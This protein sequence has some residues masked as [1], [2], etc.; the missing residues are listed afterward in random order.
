MRQDLTAAHKFSSYCRAQIFLIRPD[1]Q[2]RPIVPHASSSTPGRSGN[3]PPG[4]AGPAPPVRC[5]QVINSC[6]QT[7]A[8]RP[9]PSGV[10][11]MTHCLRIQGLRHLGRAVLAA[12]LLALGALAPSSGSLAQ[13]TPPAQAPA[14]Q[15]APS[16][17][18]RDNAGITLSPGFCATVFADNLGH[19]RHMVV[20]PDGVLY[21]NTWSGR[22]YHYD[23][24]PPGGFLVALKDTKGAGRADLVQRFGPGVP[25]GAAGGT[26]IALFKGALYSEANDR[27]VRYKLQQGEAVPKGQPDVIESRLPL[28]APHPPHPFA[29]PPNPHPSPAL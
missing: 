10:E 17:S 12:S 2:G 15:A 26:G 3:P 25:E 16:A 24:P 5:Y 18:C 7:G 13:T 28:P 29:L 9:R 22:Y 21:V 8:A 6:H 19:V 27:I 1:I 23:K 14:T 20:A 11:D 4:A